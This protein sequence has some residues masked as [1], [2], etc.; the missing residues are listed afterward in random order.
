VINL[1][2]NAIK[3]TDKGAVELC[4]RKKDDTVEIAVTDTGIGIKPE[5]LHRA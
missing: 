2:N 3:F 1:I 4:L 5:A